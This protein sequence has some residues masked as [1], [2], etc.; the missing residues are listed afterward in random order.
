M[1]KLH[2][3]IVAFIV[4]VVATIFVSNYLLN[5]GSILKKF[6]IISVENK[7]TEYEIAFDDVKAAEYYRIVIHDANNNKVLDYETEESTNV[8]SLTNLEYGT[9]YEVMV[10]AYD[11][12]GDYRPAEE[13]YM[14][15]W[16]EPSFSVDNSLVLNNEDYVLYIDGDVER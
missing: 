11:K 9:E 12:V 6:S 8:L 15:V 2:I 16:D 4:F 1:R 5:S 14:F 13:P 3:F 10:Y 7:Y